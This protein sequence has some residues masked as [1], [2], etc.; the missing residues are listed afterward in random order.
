MRILALDIAS[1]TGAAVG[2]ASGAPRLLTFGVPPAVDDA[3]GRRF[4][5]FANWLSD[6]VTVEK[7]DVLAFEAPLIVGG[8]SGTTRPTSAQ[9]IRL[10][11]GLVSIAELIAY[12]RDIEC[13]E[14]HIQTVRKFFCGDGRAKKDQVIATAVARGWMPADDN[15]ADAAA[16]WAYMMHVKGQRF[17]PPQAELRALAPGR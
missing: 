15:Q 5:A 7:P 13:W 14:C 6:L 10:L 4:A 17:V 16:I 3:L 9:T 2:D 12:Q 1:R 11:F 8:N